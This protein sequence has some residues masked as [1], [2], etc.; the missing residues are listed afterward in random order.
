MGGSGGWAILVILSMSSGSAA[1]RVGELVGLPGSS[2]AT[3]TQ[4][5]DGDLYGTTWNDGFDNSNGTVFKITPSGTMTGLYTF[6]AQTGCTD[7][8]N[9]AASLTL[10]A[11]GNFYG[12]A[13][14]GGITNGFYC[15]HGCGTVFRVTPV[16]T[17]TTVYSAAFV[18]QKRDT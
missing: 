14:K 11:D 7:G 16:G 2:Y 12:T 4:G 18:L 17:L 13:F 10:A 6:C 15:Y 3:L 1:Q 9:P 5:F 8:E